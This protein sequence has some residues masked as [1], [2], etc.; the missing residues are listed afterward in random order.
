[1]M[2]GLRRILGRGRLTVDDVH[3]LMGMAR[4]SSWAARGRVKEGE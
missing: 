4:Q 2:L 3:I 1:M